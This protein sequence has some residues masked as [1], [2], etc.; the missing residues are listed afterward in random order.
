M[1][2]DAEYLDRSK[3]VR[4]NTTKVNL[5]GS[6]HLRNLVIKCILRS[7]DADV[8]IR[9]TKALPGLTTF[10]ACWRVPT[11]D[12]MSLFEAFFFGSQVWSN[13]CILVSLS[14]GSLISIWSV[15]SIIP[16]NDSDVEGPSNLSDANGTPKSSHR[17]VK[18]SR[19]CWH[20][21]DAGG[22]IVK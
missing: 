18:I 13:A 22:P 6:Q 14:D 9:D 11:S 1:L 8:Y 3:I 20:I 10:V 19:F 4:K 16:R 15:S 12:S 21:A 7:L 2:G 17:D 5:S